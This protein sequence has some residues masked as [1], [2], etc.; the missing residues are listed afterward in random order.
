MVVYL[1]LSVGV[2][3]LIG[4]GLCCLMMASIPAFS[5]VFSKIHSVG[6]YLSVSNILYSLRKCPSLLK[7]LKLFFFPITSKH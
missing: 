6:N 3:Y 7:F 5:L 2:I 1:S 4:S